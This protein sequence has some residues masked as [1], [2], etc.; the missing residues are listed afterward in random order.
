MVRSESKRSPR[1]FKDVCM[2]SYMYVSDL[3]P[4]T[5]S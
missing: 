4:S 5:F 2:Y 3:G 1:S